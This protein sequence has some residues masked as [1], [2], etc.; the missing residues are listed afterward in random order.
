MVL[1][2]LSMTLAAALFLSLS[3]N[4]FLAGLM[5]GN[6][7]SPQHPVLAEEA[8]T[9]MSPDEARRAEWQKRDEALRAALSAADR[10]IVQNHTEAN[11]Q[12]FEAMKTRLDDA[13][14]SVA[15][16]MTAEPFDPEALDAAIET[17]TEVKATFM[18][19]MYSARRA[20]MEE[21]SPEGRQIFQEMNPLRRRGGHRSSPDAEAPG[22]EGRR[23]PHPQGRQDAAEGEERMRGRMM[24][25]RER[26]EHMRP[27]RQ[28]PP[29]P[30]SARPE[31]KAPPPAIGTDDAAMPPLPGSPPPAAP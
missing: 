5:L 4:F 10:A 20:V 6:A 8:Q 21:L 15:A 26:M 12:A 22:P 31:E 17:E 7:V 3:V 19:E 14:Q 18:R 29:P 16:A 25:R 27:M 30:G 11:K 2:K 24:E 23:P 1:N 13:R 9:R 28:A